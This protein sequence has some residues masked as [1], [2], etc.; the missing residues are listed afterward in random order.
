MHYFNLP[1]SQVTIDFNIQEAADL[2]N[3]FNFYQIYDEP[4]LKSG[5]TFS[6][7]TDSPRFRIELLEDTRHPKD[8]LFYNPNGVWELSRM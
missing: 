4:T 3:Q 8:D 2:I 1:E 5:H 7:A 6:L